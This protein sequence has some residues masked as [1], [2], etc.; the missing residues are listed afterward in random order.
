MAAALADALVDRYAIERELG[1]GGMA[2][3]YLAR[4]L[5]HGRAVA[6]KVLSADIVLPRGAERFQR[7]IRI[8]ARLQHPHILTVYDSGEAAGRQWFTMPFVEGESLRDRLQR[9]RHLP[10]GDALRVAREAAEALA[11]A[12]EHGVIHRDVTPENILLTRDGNTLV[13]DFGIARAVGSEVGARLTETGISVG[14]PEYMSPEQITGA[15]E[16]DARTDVYSLGCVLYEMLAGEPPFTGRT[17]QSIMAKRFAGAAPLVRVLR[18][19]VPAPLEAAVATALSREPSDRFPTAAA[20]ARALAELPTAPVPQPEVAAPMPASVE[21]RSPRP[22]VAAAAAAIILAGAALALRARWH[23]GTAAAPGPDPRRIAVLYF[24]DRSP[25]RS[26]GYLANGISETLIHELSEVPGLAVISRNGVAPYRGASVGP[27]SIARALRV[28]TIIDGTLDL[29]RDSLRLIV[30]MVRAPGGEE[31]GSSTVRAARGDVLGLQDSLGKE[32]SI[33]LRQ[34]LGREVRELASKSGTR[35]AAAWELE[36]RALALASDVDTLV[37]SG[38]TVAARRRLADADSLLASASGLDPR[39]VEPIVQRGWVA[40]AIERIA[41]LNRTM[42]TEWIPRGL[43]FAGQALS[44][45]P[46]DPDALRLRGTLRYYAYLLNLD[47]PPL[48]PGQLLDAAEQDLRAGAALGSPNRA[49]ALMLL[50]HLLARKS[51]PLE[52][53][54]AAQDAYETDPYLTEAATILWRLFTASLDLEEGPEA[55]KWCKEG[56]ARFPQD[57]VFTECQIELDALKGAK[58]DV[59]EAWRLLARNVNLY[60]PQEREFRR[61][62]GE[63]LVAMTIGRAGLKDSARAVALRARTDDQDIDPT[64]ELAYLEVLLW[65]LLDDR[66]E[67]LSRL[68]LYLAV[69]PQDRAS[70]AADST[71]WLRGLRNDPRFRQLVQS[72]R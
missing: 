52:S 14:T 65:N 3:V 69:N 36:Q 1:R 5:K 64:R 26:L 56:Y 20:F 37:A 24:E 59:D 32:V 23:P 44:L 8:A 31:I 47:L 45:E 21:R 57:P 53:K 40:Y 12:H 54:R 13:A 16:L 27:D 34:L 67:A 42:A 50:S 46:A 71:W 28:G 55:S 68:A 43:A 58:P 33:R 72:A 17:P 60:P 51:Q 2:T 18:P 63:L 62:R 10:L 49:R 38:D 15:T 9:D 61:R 6:L 29:E 35:S 7:E 4:D 30:A 66:Q 25:G 11:Y 19:T 70:V 39:W 48:A 22:L 41:G